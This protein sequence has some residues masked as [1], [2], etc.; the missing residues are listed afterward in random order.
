MLLCLF[1]FDELNVDQKKKKLIDKTSE[2]CLCQSR[3]NLFYKKI[4][5]ALELVYQFSI[6]DPNLQKESICYS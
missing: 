6:I 4:N 3:I 2:H 1:V 5:N